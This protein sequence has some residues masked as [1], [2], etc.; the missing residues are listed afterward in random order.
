M[1]R[2]PLGSGSFHEPRL[3]GTSCL[4]KNA[5]LKERPVRTTSEIPYKS[6]QK[7]IRSTK[8]ILCKI[9]MFTHTRAALGRMNPHKIRVQGSGAE[10]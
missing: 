6:L 1:G 4:M 9:C 3:L 10:V 7:Q 2:G 8:T 5:E